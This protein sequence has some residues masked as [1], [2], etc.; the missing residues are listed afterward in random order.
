M[1]KFRFWDKCLENYRYDLYITN[2][3]IF[4]YYPDGMFSSGLT[5]NNVTDRF[6]VEYSTGLKDKNGR[7]I[8]EGDIVQHFAFSDGDL[9][10]VKWDHGSGSWSGHGVFGEWIKCKVRGNINENPELLER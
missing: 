8:Y 9:F 6:V 1:R 2:K 7:E 3:G 10:T 4:E 5:W